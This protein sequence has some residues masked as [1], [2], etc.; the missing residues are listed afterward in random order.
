MEEDCI[1]PFPVFGVEEC[2][3]SELDVLADDWIGDVDGF[4]Y[5]GVDGFDFGC[6]PCESHQH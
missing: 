2:V 4:A 3:V 6:I 1:E 5:Q